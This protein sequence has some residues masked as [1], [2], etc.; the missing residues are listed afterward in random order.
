MVLGAVYRDAGHGAVQG[1]YREQVRCEIKRIAT[2]LLAQTVRRSRP[3]AFDLA[4]NAMRRAHRAAAS[5]YGGTAAMHRRSADV[6]QLPYMEATPCAIAFKLT[7]NARN[8]S[9][10][11]SDCPDPLGTLSAVCL[12][13]NM[14]GCEKWSSMC[15]SNPPGIQAFCGEGLPILI[16]DLDDDDDDD[17]DDEDKDGG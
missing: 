4:E 14:R 15:K 16:P 5:I 13:M 9:N 12:S 6:S 10:L 7:C 11:P 3:L 17:D 2:S 8:R 1:L